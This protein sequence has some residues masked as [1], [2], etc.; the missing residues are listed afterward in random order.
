[1]KIKPVFAIRPLRKV[2]ITDF[3]IYRCI[4]IGGFSKVYLSKCNFTGELCA[5][6][7]ISKDYI[8]KNKKQKLLFNERE[9]LGGLNH[10][11]LVSLYYAFETKNFIVF[12][13]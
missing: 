9:V 1:M 10:R 11:N 7:F 3:E 13:L 5:L 2:N 8:L 4:G 12:V 6:K